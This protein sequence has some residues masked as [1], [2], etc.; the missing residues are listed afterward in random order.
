MLILALFQC[1]SI[2]NNEKIGINEVEVFDNGIL[3]LTSDTQVAVPDSLI[4]I[5]MRCL[6]LYSGRGRVIL[7]VVS[8]DSVFVE[9]PEK[10]TIGAKYP[11]A[12]ANQ[13][14]LAAEFMAIDRFEQDWKVFL[15]ENET[16]YAFEGYVYLDSVRTPEDSL[17][18][19]ESEDARELIPPGS[20]FHNYASSERFLFLSPPSKL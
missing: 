20:K 14:D 11:G 15:K 12:L 6:P 16:G 3:T 1:E 18:H 10:D 13:I 2:S 8:G 4:T 17:V 9:A 7:Q 19:I 5:K